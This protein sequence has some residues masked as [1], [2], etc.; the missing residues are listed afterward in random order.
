MARCGRECC[1]NHHRGTPKPIVYSQVGKRM[2]AIADALN[3]AGL[4]FAFG[5]AIALAYDIENPR[6]TI[7]IDIDIL[8]EP[9]SEN[10]AGIVK[11]L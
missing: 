1:R 10:V 7:D 8:V 11:V 3:N 4:C 5:G 6:A 9:T 2:L